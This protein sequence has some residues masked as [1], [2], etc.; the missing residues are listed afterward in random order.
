MQ[1]FHG[2]FIFAVI[3]GIGILARCGLAHEVFLLNIVECWFSGF[4]A[5]G[6]LAVGETVNPPRYLSGEHPRK[7]QKDT[8][9]IFILYYH[10]EYR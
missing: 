3:D 6:V 10:L 7:Q 9:H 5:W 2:W 8:Y 1:I 4:L